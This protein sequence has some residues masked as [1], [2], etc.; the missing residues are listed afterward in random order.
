MSLFGLRSITA[1]LAW[2]YVIMT[3][4]A[5]FLISI[6]LYFTLTNIAEKSAKQYL[7]DEMDYIS[8]VLRKHEG[9]ISLLEHEINW[10][11]G[12][13]ERAEEQKS[14]WI[15][16][17][18]YIRIIDKKNIL[19]ETPGMRE[20][21]PEKA[22]AS[23]S[24]FEIGQYQ[25]ENSHVFLVI[26]SG[27]KLSNQTTRTVQI[28]LDITSISDLLNRYR[29][30]LLISILITSF[31]IVISAIFVARKAL[32]PLYELSDKTRE[33][34]AQ[35]LSVRL[36]MSN[37]PVEFKQLVDA[38]NAMLSRLEKSYQRLELF[39]AELAHELRTPLNNLMGEAEVAL[40]KPRDPAEYQSLLSSSLEEY[41]RI[42]QLIEQMLLLAKLEN[43]S[44]PPS[45]ENLDALQSIQSVLSYF[46]PLLEEKNIHL[47]CEISG[48]IQ[49][50][51]MLW[52]R[53]LTNLIDNAIKYTPDNGEIRLTGS[54]I[55]HKFH[56][57]IQ[58][59][60]IGI[61]ADKIPFLFERFYRV[62][63]SHQPGFGLGLSIAASIIHLHQGT[64]EIRSEINQGTT[65]I[66]A[67]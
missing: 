9:S 19:G 55:K 14:R 35:D 20:L 31:L 33:I 26:H 3:I 65:V 37:W 59:N 30:I 60:G 16:P 50:N 38:L 45:V 47:E 17:F 46:E 32:K 34:T 61:A 57:Q 54:T 4:S 5:L 64:I 2:F 23:F 11:P 1:R 56:L 66:I 7:T 27:L 21:L 18:D 39:S 52:Q 41:H 24:E 12:P 43:Q 10:I 53:A 48:T 40:H 49:V 8:T 13:I 22:F 63:H 6:I 25:S 29:Q 58:D 15:L 36:Q 67:L 28:G 51:K 42:N 44:L 62:E